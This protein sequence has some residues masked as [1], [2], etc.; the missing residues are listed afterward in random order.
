MG[1]PSVAPIIRREIDTGGWRTSNKGAKED[2]V[3]E[4]PAS[5]TPEANRR[6]LSHKIGRRNTG[7]DFDYTPVHNQARQSVKG[8]F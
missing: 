4:L 7:F 8:R 2:I 3:A 1:A 6:D 5:R